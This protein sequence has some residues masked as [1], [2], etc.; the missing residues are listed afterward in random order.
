MA[1]GS[2]RPRATKL[3]VSKLVVVVAGLALMTALMSPATGAATPTAHA[4]PI[5][6]PKGLPAFYSVPQP[7]PTKIGKL[8]KSQQIASTGVDGTVYRVMYVSE[9]QLGKP[10]A[11]TGLV[12]VPNTPAPAGGYP[13]VSWGHGTNGMAD[14]CTPSLDPTNDVPL[15]NTLLDQGWEVTSSDYQGEGTP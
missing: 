14:S 9:T 1:M 7:I 2:F 5:P 11:V 15:E 3:G 8:I 6:A 10:V 12:I 4:K 13:V